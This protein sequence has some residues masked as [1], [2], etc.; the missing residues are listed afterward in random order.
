MKNCRITVAY[1]PSLNVR[2]SNNMEPLFL[3]F[4]VNCYYCALTEAMPK[5]LFDI[6]TMTMS[7]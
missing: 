6:G 3:R 7:H 5:S 4:H 1:K 2:M